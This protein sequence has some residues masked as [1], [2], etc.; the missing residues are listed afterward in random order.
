MHCL[1]VYPKEREFSRFDVDFNL[2]LSRNN[3]AQYHPYLLVHSFAKIFRHV[4]TCF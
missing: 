2:V 4:E 3:K 1:H